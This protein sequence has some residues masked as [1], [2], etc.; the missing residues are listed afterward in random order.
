MQR[1]CA[2]LKHIITQY[3]SQAY[4]YMAYK[5][6][7]KLLI[8]TKDISWIGHTLKLHRCVRVTFPSLFDIWKVCSFHLQHSQERHFAAAELELKR[9]KS[10]LNHQRRTKLQNQHPSFLEAALAFTVCCISGTLQV[11]VSKTMTPELDIFK[12]KFTN[13]DY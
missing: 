12:Q 11:F 9:S 3:T 2:K 1:L 8:Q 5:L 4:F 7:K 13:R 10:A 6:I